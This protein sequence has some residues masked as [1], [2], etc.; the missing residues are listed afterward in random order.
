VLGASVLSLT[1]RNHD[2][3]RL[4]GRE[5]LSMQVRLRRLLILGGFAL[6]LIVGATW[7]RAQAL[8]QIETGHVVVSGSDVGFRIVGRRGN[9]PIGRLVI[10]QNGEWVEVEAPQVV[11]PLSLK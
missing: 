5:G 11:R 7:G 9:T 3:L 2:L 8:P 4:T 6:A 1:G 10:R